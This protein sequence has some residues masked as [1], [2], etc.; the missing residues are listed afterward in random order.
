MDELNLPGSDAVCDG[1]WETKVHPKA[2]D[3]AERDE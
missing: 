3:I 1:C 2:W